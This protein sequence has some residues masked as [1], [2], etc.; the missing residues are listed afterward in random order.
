MVIDKSFHLI[1]DFEYQK[2]LI[3]VLLEKSRIKDVNLIVN[4]LMKNNNKSN[5]SLEIIY[6]DLM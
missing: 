2:S 5:I 4:Y 3:Q 1:I 6:P